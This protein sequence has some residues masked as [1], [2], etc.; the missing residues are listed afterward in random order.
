MSMGTPSQAWQAPLGPP[1]GPSF[2]GQ[3]QQ[4]QQPGGMGSFDPQAIMAWLTQVAQSTQGLAL[5]PNMLQG[6]ATLM[7]MLGIYQQMQ[8]QQTQSDYMA[9][10]HQS[11]GLQGQQLADAQDQLNFQKG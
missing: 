7:P 3:P 6:I 9:W 4:P 10:L 5:D 8:Q 11:L 2:A 1:P